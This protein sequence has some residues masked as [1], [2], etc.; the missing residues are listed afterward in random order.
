R[1]K[2]SQTRNNNQLK[3]HKIPNW[4]KN[5]RFIPQHP[6]IPNG[7]SVE[8]TNTSDGTSQEKETCKKKGLG[9]GTWRYP[10]L[11]SITQTR[12]ASRQA[13]L[14]VYGQGSSQLRLEQ[15]ESTEQESDTRDRSFIINYS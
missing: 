10:I 3:G 5:N 4:S 6:T 8:A 1:C 9:F 11:K 13:T 12:R 2:S 15:E 7:K 14:Q